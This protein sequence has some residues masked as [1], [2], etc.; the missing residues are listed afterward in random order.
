MENKFRKGEGMRGKKHS[1][2]AERDNGMKKKGG[3]RVQIADGGVKKRWKNKRGEDGTE[4]KVI[5]AQSFCQRLQG[6]VKRSCR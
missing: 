5:K 4:S 6:K 2:R 1:R 3:G